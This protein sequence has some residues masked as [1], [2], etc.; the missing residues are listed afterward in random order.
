MQCTT[1]KKES[2]YLVTANERRLCAACLSRE[3]DKEQITE[4]L[5]DTAERRRLKDDLYP[6]EVGERSTYCIRCMRDVEAGV[7][8]EG[9]GYCIAC[10]LE[11]Q[12]SEMG[13]LLK[14]FDETVI[15]DGVTTG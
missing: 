7:I 10:A 2:R 8:L 1:C 3:D 14:V 13:M 5:R 4:R 12:P 15:E 6:G 11:I 9:R